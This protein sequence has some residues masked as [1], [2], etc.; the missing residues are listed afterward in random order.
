MYNMATLKIVNKANG[1][2]FFAEDLKVKY[3]TA[4]FSSCQHIIITTDETEDAIT[5][6]ISKVPDRNDVK[7]EDV[8]ANLEVFEMKD[9]TPVNVLSIFNSI[10]SH[11]YGI[12]EENIVEIVADWSEPGPSE[13]GQKLAREKEEFFKAAEVFQKYGY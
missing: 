10:V 13:L 5:D 2:F 1:K 7:K 4:K 9:E 6:V 12:S 11:I 3:P 8:V